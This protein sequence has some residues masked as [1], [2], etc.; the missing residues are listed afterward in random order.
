MMAA[1]A[2]GI[3]SCPMGGFEPEAVAEVLKLD[4][5]RFEVAPLVAVDDRRGAARP[6]GQTDPRTRPRPLSTLRRRLARHK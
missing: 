4:R 1:A 3:D 5:A 2:I 6:V